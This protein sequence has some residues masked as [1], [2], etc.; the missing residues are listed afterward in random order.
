MQSLRNI[1]HLPV[2]V[3]DKLKRMR[4]LQ[5]HLKTLQAEYDML[6]KDV[7]NDHFIA[8]PEYR[9]DKG[10]LLASYNGVERLTFNQTAFKT[11]HSDLFEQFQEKKIIF[12]FLLK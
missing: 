8:N 3:E 5:T 2:T 6:K 7:I 10:L 9:T 1:F 12:T 4:E 11:A